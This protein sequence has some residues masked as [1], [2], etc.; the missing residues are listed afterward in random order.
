MSFILFF[1]TENFTA[2]KIHDAMAKSLVLNA[3]H[4]PV[5]PENFPHYTYYC[6]AVT[7]S[8]NIN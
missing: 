2:S 8:I 4:Y 5:L 3:H 1:Q 6:A 7:I